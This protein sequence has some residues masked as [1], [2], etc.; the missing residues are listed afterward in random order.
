MLVSLQSVGQAVGQISG[1]FHGAVC[2]M[3][4]E[5]GIRRK[6]PELFESGPSEPG[7]SMAKIIMDRHT[8]VAR[9]SV[10][11]YTRAA[12]ADDA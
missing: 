2:R 9:L 1:K 10:R 8:C 5:V 12:D 7:P 4:G 6:V 3:L 11:A